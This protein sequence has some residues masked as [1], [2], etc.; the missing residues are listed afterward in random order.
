MEPRNYQHTECLH[1]WLC[2]RC[3][4]WFK[5]PASVEARFAQLHYRAEAQNIGRG[6]MSGSDSPVNTTKA[7]IR[8]RPLWRFFSPRDVA[9]VN[10]ILHPKR[11]GSRRVRASGVSTRALP[12]WVTAL[13]P[14]HLGC[15]RARALTPQR[16]PLGGLLQS[17]VSSCVL[18][19]AHSRPASSDVNVSVHWLQVG[20]PSGV[21][22]SAVPS[23]I[24]RDPE[25]S[26]TF[27]EICHGQD[28]R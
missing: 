6:Q 19:L 25:R 14:C 27:F 16:C 17:A 15:Q 21:L 18:R 23:W 2:L 8:V 22:R 5:L 3:S 11:P 4:L 13:A 12:P 20:A 10:P 1:R 9:E 26:G 7:P 24:F 28:A